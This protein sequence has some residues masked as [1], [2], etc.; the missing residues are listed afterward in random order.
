MSIITQ[1]LHPDKNASD[2]MGEL[3]S[4]KVGTRYIYRERVEQGKERMR[5][6]Q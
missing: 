2:L 3:A 5:R 6:H 4:V 1:V